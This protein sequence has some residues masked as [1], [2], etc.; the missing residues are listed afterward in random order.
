MTK[1]TLALFV[2]A[3]V[4][5]GCA[6]GPNPA[7]EMAQSGACDPAGFWLGFWHGLIA[8]FTFIGSLFSDNVS[9]YE[10]CNTGGWYDFGFCLGIGMF[11]SSSG[12]SANRRGRR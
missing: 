5:A 4:M 10:V 2:F 7:L 6:P 1:L 8:F 9:V 11:S 3:A 12:A